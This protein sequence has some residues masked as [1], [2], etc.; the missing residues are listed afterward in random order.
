MI[1]WSLFYTRE[2]SSPGAQRGLAGAQ[3]GPVTKVLAVVGVPPILKLGLQR[4]ELLAFLAVTVALLA[5]DLLG[6][7]QLSL[8]LT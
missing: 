2:V 5:A 8:A 4:G 3:V 6:D 7:D 1:Y